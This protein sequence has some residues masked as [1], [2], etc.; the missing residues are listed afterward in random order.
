MKTI[1]EKLRAFINGEIPPF[2]AELQKP[3]TVRN[4]RRIIISTASPLDEQLACMPK[5]NNDEL[6]DKILLFKPN[7]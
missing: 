2:R 7:V 5:L 6:K 4:F 1:E 3:I